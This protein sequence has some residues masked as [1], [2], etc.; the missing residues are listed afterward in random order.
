VRVEMKF[1]FARDALGAGETVYHG[2]ASCLQECIQHCG[3]KLARDDAVSDGQCMLVLDVV[4]TRSAGV[5][6]RF[7][8]AQ[9]CFA[10]VSASGFVFHVEKVPGGLQGAEGGVLHVVGE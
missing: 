6:R 4:V 8:E 2:Q 10:A 5:L 7:Q 3:A 9:Q 1:F